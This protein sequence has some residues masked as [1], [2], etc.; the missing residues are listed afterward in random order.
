MNIS[1]NDILKC[2]NLSIK[3]CE[4]SDEYTKDIY[5]FDI[6]S[7]DK[8]CKYHTELNHE[9]DFLAIKYKVYFKKIVKLLD[10]EL[11]KM[12]K[13]NENIKLLDKLYLYRQEIIKNIR[14]NNLNNII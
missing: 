1:I 9:F 13:I 7:F 2:I 8:M 10:D 3:Y 12:M 4:L 5:N 14:L 11:N 6:E